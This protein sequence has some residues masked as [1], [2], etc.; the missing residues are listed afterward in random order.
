MVIHYGNAS[1]NVITMLNVIY[2]APGLLIKGETQKYDQYVSKYVQILGYNCKHRVACVKWMG[3]CMRWNVVGI[4]P[5]T[6]IAYPSRLE[7]YIFVNRTIL[8]YSQLLTVN[9]L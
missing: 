1:Y 4:N 2:L 9:I 8:R 3:W 7:P 5:F 6:S